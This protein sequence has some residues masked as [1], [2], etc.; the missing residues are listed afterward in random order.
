MKSLIF[1]ALV[2]FGLALAIGGRGY[3][4]AQEDPRI[5]QGVQQIDSY[6]QQ[7]LTPEAHDTIAK[8]ARESADF[9]KG[10]EQRAVDATR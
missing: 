7:G 4:D 10:I 2:I 5:Q 6:L 8:N 3:T 1:A 9:L